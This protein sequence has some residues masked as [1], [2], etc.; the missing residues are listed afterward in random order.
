MQLDSISTVDRSHRLTLLSRVG[1]YPP[2]TVSRLLRAGRLFEYWA[3]EA[4][5]L[6]I[7]RLAAACA[8]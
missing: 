4:C 7:E 5:L 8:A 3:H 2:G 6:P 1:R